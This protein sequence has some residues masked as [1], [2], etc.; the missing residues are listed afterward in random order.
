MIVPHY[1]YDY[2]YITGH[3]LTP[4]ARINR[5]Q[6]AVIPASSDMFHRPSSAV[7]LHSPA[8]QSRGSPPPTACRVSAVSCAVGAP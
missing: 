7:F 2:T 3:R 6:H 4:G 8:L 1:T 5:H